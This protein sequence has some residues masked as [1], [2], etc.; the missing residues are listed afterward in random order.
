MV[1]EDRSKLPYNSTL[2]SRVNNYSCPN[3]SII[4]VDGAQMRSHY[5]WG[6]SLHLKLV[7]VFAFGEHGEMTCDELIH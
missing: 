7:F 1:I 6:I 3:R 2:N 5:I 4:I